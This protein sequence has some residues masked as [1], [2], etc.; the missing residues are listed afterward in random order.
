MKRAFWTKLDDGSYGVRVEAGSI[1]GD[2]VEVISSKG[3]RTKG[4]LGE[5]VTVFEVRKFTSK[6][7]IEKLTPQATVAIPYEPEP[8][9]FVIPRDPDFS[10]EPIKDRK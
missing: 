2:E 6:R 4:V 7:D 1:E 3:R 9:T 8:E 10:Y 5:I